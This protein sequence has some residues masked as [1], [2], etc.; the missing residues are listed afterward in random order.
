MIGSPVAFAR[1]ANDSTGCPGAKRCPAVPARCGSGSQIDSRAA[2]AP[3]GQ[4]QRLRGNES[5]AR[6]WKQ[7]HTAGEVARHGQA[8]RQEPRAASAKRRRRASP[9]TKNRGCGYSSPFS[10][11]LII[12]RAVLNFASSAPASFARGCF[13]Q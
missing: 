6:G 2:H 9:T 1:N 5:L 3:D 7:E 4:L 8:A 13:F 12:E 11:L 10:I